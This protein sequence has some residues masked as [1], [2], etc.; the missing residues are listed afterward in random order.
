MQNN[1]LCSF[2]FGRRLSEMAAPSITDWSVIPIDEDSVNITWMTGNETSEYENFYFL[3]YRQMGDNFT[4]NTL[5]FT[6]QQWQVL[7]NLTSGLWYEFRVVMV[8]NGLEFPSDWRTLLLPLTSGEMDLDFLQ[9]TWFVVMMIAI[10]V[11]LLILILVCIIKCD[12]GSKYYVKDDCLSNDEEEQKTEVDGTEASEKDS[13]DEY[14]STSTGQFN[15][16]GSIIK[17]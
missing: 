9:T 7:S 11:L 8:Q 16:E 17:D 15:E 10:C 14:K 4:E 1:Q 3:E 6:T 13:L 12:R 2:R 5:E